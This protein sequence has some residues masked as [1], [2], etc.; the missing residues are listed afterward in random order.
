MK[1]NAANRKKWLKVHFCFELLQTHM[2]KIREMIPSNACP[3]CEKVRRVSFAWSHFKKVDSNES[4][5]TFHTQQNNLR[6]TIF[7]FP[8]IITK[9]RPSSFKII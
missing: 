8:L 9:M 3:F 6:A 1:Y 4:K 5:V 7:I 2:L